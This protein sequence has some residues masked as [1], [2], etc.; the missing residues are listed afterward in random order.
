[1]YLQNK[2]LMSEYI[3][4]LSTIYS[5]KIIIEMIK[6]MKVLQINCVY[7][8][9]STGKL[10]QVL[11]RGLKERHLDSTV[12]FG[13][14]EF[15]KE[16]GVYRVCGDFWGKINHLISRFTGLMYGG[17]F[18]STFLIKKIIK[19]ENP[20][21][22][23]LHCINGYF[24]NIY[25]LV[26]WLKINKFSTVITLHAEFF[27]TAN[28]GH[29][30]ECDRWRK[31]CGNCPRLKK[32]TESVFI[33]RTAQSFK[34]MKLAIDG[35]NEKLKIVSVSPW[36]M[37]RA[38][39]S[40]IL[41]DKRHF[42]VCN[43]V[44]TKIFRNMLSPEM[45]KKLC[46]NGEKMIFHATAYFSDDVDDFKGGFWILKLAERMKYNNFKFVVAGDARLKEKTPDN[47]I[48]LGKISDQSKLAKLYSIAD[49]TLLVSKKETF[50]M[51]VAESL[52]CGTPVI[53][54]KAGAPEQIAIPEYSEFYEQGDL[55]S[56]EKGIN[57]WT[58]CVDKADIAQRAVEYYSQ[59]KMIEKYLNIYRSF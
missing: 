1:M 54:F 55:D 35:F 30:L 14:G 28:C 17:C 48:V 34:K 53:G 18:F 15:C 11:H 32:E 16:H 12:I 6:N 21:V 42:C 59:K 52:C 41:K 49:V 24:V 2:Y 26:E 46:P 5:D 3:V 57:R 39:S 31:G 45:K 19:R 47:V 23:N 4:Q 56:L 37:E 22:V 44:N 38:I 29:A 58:N 33:D 10:V 40:P 20:D 50:S 8:V 43:G 7:G 25:K 27:Y 36:I 13:R 9:G 51:V